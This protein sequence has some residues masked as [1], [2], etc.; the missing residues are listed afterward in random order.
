M[1]ISM[2][3]VSTKSFEKSVQGKL[4]FS[5]YTLEYL[6]SLSFAPSESAILY[7][8]EGKTGET[9][10]PFEKF[11]FN[12]DFGE[13]FSG[14][15]RPGTFILHWDAT[16][17]SQGKPKHALEELKSEENVRFG[18]A[19]FSPNSDR[20][21]YATG[22]E[23]T[24]DGRMLGLKWCCNRP[25]GIWQLRLPELL[26]P[27]SSDKLN[28]TAVIAVSSEKLTS[29]SLSCR[30]PR[31]FIHGAQS[32]LSWLACPSGGAHAGAS[33]LYCLDISSDSDTSRPLDSI[34]KPL[35]PIT[36]D[37]IPSSP[38]VFPGLYLP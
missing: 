30:S 15:K 1:G 20:I 16:K 18:Q 32:T 22:Y 28:P 24:I 11:R 36:K 31:T 29:P 38:H 10:D 19:L 2:Q 14:K 27:E 35:V 33:A 25:S 12:P 37:E 21:I 6:A 7:T 5:V 9:K 8:A 26:L 17:N 3:M 34:D 23:F 4:I 13:G